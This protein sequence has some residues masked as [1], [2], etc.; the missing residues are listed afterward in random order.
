MPFDDSNPKILNVEQMAR[1][2]KSRAKK[3]YSYNCESVVRMLLE[4]LPARRCSICKILN[5]KWL[6]A[7]VASQND[8]RKNFDGSSIV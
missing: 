6:K 8:K 1:D 4:P 2:Y 3:E 7:H 5:A